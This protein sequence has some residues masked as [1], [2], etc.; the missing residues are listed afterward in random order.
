MLKDLRLRAEK[1]AGVCG[2]GA[3][4]PRC[5][6]IVAGGRLVWGLRRLRAKT[7]FL[8]ARPPSPWKHP[9]QQPSPGL[10]SNW[11]FAASLHTQPPPHK[12]KISLCSRVLLG[13]RHSSEFPSYVSLAGHQSLG[14]RP[15]PPQSHASKEPRCG[16][17]SGCGVR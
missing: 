5:R 2:R 11:A 17:E 10:F 16:G 6:A 3:N 13:A 8:C 4:R 9:S 14:A 12:D 1:L 7:F 15:R